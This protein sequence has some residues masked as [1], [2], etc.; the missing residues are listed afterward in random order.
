MTI[1]TERWGTF[2]VSLEGPKEGNPFLD[3]Q[4]SA[5]FQYKHRVVDAEG[6]YDGD[7]IY[8]VRFMP[9]TAGTWHYITHSN[10][11]ELDGVTGE[12]NCT[13]PSPENH[14]PVRV[15]NTYHFAYA[16]GTP[17]FPFGTTCYAWIHQGDELED[18]TMA[19]LK[20]S[21]F[22]KLR[23]C[24]FPKHYAYNENEPLY[25]PYEWDGEGR[26]DFGRFNPEFFRHLEKRIEGLLTIGVEADLILFHPYDRWG[27]AS[28]DAETDDAYLHYVVAR[29]AGFRNVW[30]SMANEFDLMKKKGMAD[31]DRFFRI[32]QEC[33][34]YQHP[35][36]VHNCR[37]FYDHGKPWVT[38]QSIQHSELEK[39]DRWR[40]DYGKPV[41]VDECR[42]EGNIQQRWGNIAAQE[43]IRRF[44]EGT[45][46]GGYVGH[47]ETYRHPEDILWWSK[48]GVLHGQSPARIAFLRMILEEGPAEG[49]DPVD[50]VRTGRFPCA[51]KEGD[52]YLCY[53]G[54][55]QPAQM[56]FDLPPS[57]RYKVEII[58]T[59]EMTITS[60]EGSFEGRFQIELPGKP[61]IAVRIQRDLAQ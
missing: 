4:L 13:P 20:S 18:K 6:F 50:S 37:A 57:Q 45:V 52:Y 42:Y 22:N 41:V 48:G 30:W 26:W 31:W 55:H 36:S 58:D 53:F 24:I 60:K 47:G 61:H 51:G 32:V 27:Y 56:T 38:H 23:M 49:L 25:H 33:D 29:L 8:R 40:A 19:T 10:H 2:D 5:Q 15:R 7:G 12:F 17:Y 35:R 44:W 43:M 46:R 54:V 14:G 28:M 16:D 21:P 11:G 34:P 39:V 9:D 1:Q 3:V 59:W